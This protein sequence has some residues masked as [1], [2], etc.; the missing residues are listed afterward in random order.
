[1]T[2]AQLF[3]KRIFPVSVSFFLETFMAAIL[4]SVACRT[5]GAVYI[6][7][8][9]ILP[10]LSLSL[11]LP[12]ALT[13]LPSGYFA[14]HLP[15][16]SL[17]ILSRLLELFILL[18]GIVLA[19]FDLTGKWMVP[20]LVT[21][22]SIKSA[23]Y[24][25]ALHGLLPETF[26]EKELSRANGWIC[27][28]FFAAI[29]CCVP[30]SSYCPWLADNDL[31]DLFWLFA[32][33]SFIGLISS[34]RIGHSVSAI[35]KKRELG[36]SW[37]NTASVGFREV[38]RRPPLFLTSLGDSLFLALG[39]GMLY[40]ISAV[41]L[42]GNMEMD[43]LRVTLFA[44]AL[45][46]AIGC[47]LAGKLSGSKIELGLIPFGVFGAAVALPFSIYFRGTPTLLTLTI[48][49]LYTVTLELYIPA[50]LFL[51]TAGVC[52]GLFIVPLRSYFQHR[53]KAYATG[54]AF[55][56]NHM[57]GF[58]MLVG[59]MI[60]LIRAVP[61]PYSKGGSI[62]SPYWI[63][64]FLGLIM[65]FA[66][67]VTMW[68]LPGFAL[69]FLTISLGN[70][71]YRI[72]LYGGEHIPERGGAILLS[73]HVSFIDSVL[74]SA[75]T[76]RRVRFLMEEDYFRYPLLSLVARLTGFIRVPKG[77]KDKLT[78]MFAEIKTALIKGDIICVFPEGRMTRNGVL[79]QFHEG[80]KRMLPEGVDVPVIPVCIGSMWGSVFS[81]S[82][83]NIE[84][85]IPH[86]LPFR[87]TVSF[88]K[89]LKKDCTAFHVRQAVA[90]LAAES[91]MARC[92]KE[93]TLH[94][95]LLRE[96][97]RS[98]FKVRLRDYDGTSYTML[99]TVCSAILISREIRRYVG[100]DVKYTGILLPN[101]ALEGISILS[102]LYADKAPAILNPTTAASVFEASIRKAGITHILT[103]HAYVERCPVIL[104][105]VTFLYLDDILE[106]MPRWK[107]F[108]LSAAIMILPDHELISF[109]SPLSGDHVFG[110]AVLL[111]SSGSTGDP[112]GVMLTHHNMYTNAMATA[113]LLNVIPD[114]DHILGNLPLFH[115]FGLNT[116]FWLPMLKQ[117]N[118]TYVDNPLD[119][120]KVGVV[121]KNFPVTMLFATPSFLQIYLK[122]CPQECFRSIRLTITGAEKL[123]AGLLDK[124]KDVMAG[125]REIVE[126]YGC[127]ELSPM[128]TLNLASDIQD[129]GTMIG[130]AD[131]IGVS[132]N[133]ISAK[134]VDPLTFEP[135]DSNTEGIL[136][137]KGPNV[138]DG[139]LSDPE[140]TKKVLHDG[141][142]NT[143]D[144]VKMDNKGYV[145]ICGRLSRFSKIA[146]EM[147]PH[148]MVE[149]IINEL[150]CPEGRGV[151]VCSMPDA[152]KGEALMILYTS[153]MRMTP[154]EVV[155]ELRERSI[156]N[157]WIPKAINFHPVDTL[158]L[159]GSGKLNLLA[160]RE[161]ADRIV[162]EL[163]EKKKQA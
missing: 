158:P 55:A 40:L 11:V 136:V 45:G 50:I 16:R 42:S 10:Y 98:P 74:I 78:G 44:T 152:A 5:A 117:C 157:L 94:Y 111:F 30:V 36:Y 29:A 48:P 1:M 92:P 31:R 35:Q 150:A 100:S 38:F 58:M 51:L 95:K 97:S 34:I 121:L 120:S 87:V 91:N 32:V 72:K 122:K 153:D 140:L 105:D 2:A 137:V 82:N 149:H 37:Q 133:N 63:I 66:T 62:F 43:G 49:R 85:R 69:R 57:I 138:M 131:S 90:E 3:S 54:A 70:L 106:Q 141:Y 159:L 76:S 162:K 151:A 23:C 12:F 115:S 144:V 116:G 60:F 33:L 139:Y 132:L 79:G 86:E 26:H 126:A 118:V 89:P 15:K 123:R 112:K 80:Y 6:F 107:K 83:G 14:D 93:R 110:V 146:G 59:V 114:Q 113:E 84:W 125:Q 20:F 103:T 73:N 119:A 19:K 147:V 4:L 64:A 154:E 28:S 104:P 56:I 39:G 7:E 127:T 47:R 22:F 67:F 65:F 8:G 109:I 163:E 41:L 25:P 71:L 130:K 18:C 156:S 135:V 46:G 61:I 13:L 88:G 68:L 148:E 96:A 102:V 124:F 17:I 21:M 101:S 129:L 128:V 155:A 160:L 9:N 161:I 52:V 75:C 142:Y 53:L 108:L 27:F 99:Q 134:V 145:T 143:G 77:G 24:L 81:Y